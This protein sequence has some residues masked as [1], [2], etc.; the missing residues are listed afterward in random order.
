MYKNVNQFATVANLEECIVEAFN[1]IDT[2]VRH[3]L[4]RSMPKTFVEVIEIKG[5]KTHY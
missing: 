3:I 5:S 1:K 2:Y 4:H